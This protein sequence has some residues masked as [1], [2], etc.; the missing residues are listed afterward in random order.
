MRLL[1]KKKL[2]SKGENINRRTNFSIQ[3]AILRFHKRR[4]QVDDNFDHIIIVQLRCNAMI[5][6]SLLLIQIEFC[7]S[8]PATNRPTTC[9]M[10][11]PFSFSNI[12]QMVDN[13][14]IELLGKHIAFHLP[15]H[16]T[17]IKLFNATLSFFLSLPHSVLPSHSFVRNNWIKSAK[18]HFHKA[19]TLVSVSAS[20][21]TQ[22]DL[23]EKNR[24]K[25]KQKSLT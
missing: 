10:T 5:S 1:P 15:D 6:F 11:M 20:E 19:N 25:G 8:D 22:N 16:D 17:K 18:E 13:N 3:F 21:S 9:T 24:E 23:N 2:K 4:S 7:E 14:L 12:H